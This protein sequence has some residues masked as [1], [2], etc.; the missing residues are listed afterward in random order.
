[1]LLMLFCVVLAVA[2]IGYAKFRQIQAAIAM[3]KSFAP[4]PSAVTTLKLQ[5]QLWSPAITTFGSIKALQSV[6][7]TTDLAG[8]VSDIQFQSGQ[9]VKKGDLLLRLQDDQERAQLHTA[10][11]RRDFAQLELT[12]KQNLQSKNTLAS[13]EVDAA[14]NELRQASAAVEN[15][16]ALIARKQITAPFDGLLGIRQ[17][18]LGQFLNPGT[19]IV[20]MHS[21]DP[22]YVQFSLPQH[23]L[24]SASTG[25]SIR[26]LSPAIPPGQWTAKI[27]AIDSQL[28]DAS[29]SITVEATIPN[30]NQSL[31]H[32]MFVNVELPLP[33]EPD[34]LV[35]PASAI[36][37]APYGDSIY[38]VKESISKDG[39]STKIVD[40]QFVKLGDARGDQIRILSGLKDGDEIVTSGV[41]K[42]RPGAPIQINNSVQPPNE[43]APKPPNT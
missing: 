3:G 39:T 13:S 30:P 33:S 19:P 23:Q 18:S 26:V 15:A 11:A 29:R 28:N 40:Q 25:L 16:L 8:I 6:T 4:P 24:P 1:M 34:A 42:L 43:P 12:R 32:G 41:F 2:G 9:S 36:N 14:E 10:E 27:T 31:R 7:I 37:Y 35:V 5:K 20:T 22:I 17:T 38:V 21:V